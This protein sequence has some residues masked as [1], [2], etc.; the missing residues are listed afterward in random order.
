MQHFIH[1]ENVKR[2]KRLLE[3]EPDAKKRELLSKLLADEEVRYAEA[4]GA[5]NLTRGGL[6]GPE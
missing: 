5:A 6:T 4:L 3:A 2:F 1:D